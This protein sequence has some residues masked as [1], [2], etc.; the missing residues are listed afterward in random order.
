M[1][2]VDG[3]QPEIQDDRDDRDKKVQTAGVALPLRYRI[4]LITSA[5]H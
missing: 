4:L 3:R 5:K 1:C 2:S